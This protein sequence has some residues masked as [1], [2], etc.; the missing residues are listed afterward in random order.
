LGL[1]GG[2]G[3]YRRDHG[4]RHG[5][6]A[7]QK[8]NREDRGWWTSIG[9]GFAHED[10]EGMTLKLNLLPV[11]GADIVVRKAKPRTDIATGEILKDAPY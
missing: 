3:A 11:N 6:R 5:I 1:C 8:R 4:R 9:V 10:G 7:V 2:A